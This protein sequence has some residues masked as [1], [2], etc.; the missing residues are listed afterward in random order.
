[1]FLAPPQSSGQSR[2]AFRDPMPSNPIYP[3]VGLRIQKHCMVI[4]IRHAKSVKYSTSAFFHPKNQHKKRV[5]PPILKFAT[6]QR[7]LVITQKT[8]QAQPKNQ[9]SCAIKWLTLKTVLVA[10]EFVNEVVF[11]FDKKISV[12]SPPLM[13][14]RK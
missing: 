3:T 9:H 5:N 10:I 4:D 7:N 6:K 2:G 1:M 14:M 13:A 8:T 12:V 11:T